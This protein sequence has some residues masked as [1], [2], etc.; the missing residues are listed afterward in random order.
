MAAPGRD[1][2]DAIDV[3]G[4]LEYRD[5]SCAHPTFATRPAMMAATEDSS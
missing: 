3:R 5:A 1:A 4:R 2:I